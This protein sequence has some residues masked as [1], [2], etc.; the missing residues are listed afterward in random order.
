MLLTGLLIEATGGDAGT[1]TMEGSIRVDATV[2]DARV[3][4]ARGNTKTDTTV[5][6]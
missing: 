6:A 4:A 5:V 1:N 2:G 3:D